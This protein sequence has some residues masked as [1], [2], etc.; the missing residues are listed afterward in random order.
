LLLAVKFLNV[1]VGPH[2]E[3]GA[4][5]PKSNPTM[6]KQKHRL[7]NTIFAEYIKIPK[8]HKISEIKLIKYNPHIP[9][10][11]RRLRVKFYSDKY[12]NGYTE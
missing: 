11:T 2:D 4:F 9:T 6:P 8:M 12:I 3:R 10:S 5:K 7:C 1:F